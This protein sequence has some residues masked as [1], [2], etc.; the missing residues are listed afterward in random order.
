MKT[1]TV[2]VERSGYLLAEARCMWSKDNAKRLIDE[3]KSEAD[4]RGYKRILFDLRH[5]SHPNTEMTRFW[6]GE[7]LANVMRGS[8]KVAAF[9]TPEAINYFGETVAVNRGAYFRIFPDEMAAVEWLMNQPN[10][11]SEA[12]SPKGAAPQN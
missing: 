2:F 3:T 4:K 12:T 9:A 8:F 10:K 5:W 1:E 7:H 11:V 6:S